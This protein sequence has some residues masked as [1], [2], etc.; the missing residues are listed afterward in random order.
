MSANAGSQATDVYGRNLG[1]KFGAQDAPFVLT[2]SLQCPE[3]AVTEVYVN[4][5]LGRLSDPIPRVDAYMICLMLRDLPRNLYWEE[6]RQVSAF[7]LK[8]GSI[9]LEESLARLVKEG[10]VEPE[11]ARARAAHPEEFENLVRAGS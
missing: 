6:G 11:E 10:L 4:Q 5:P 7:S 9:T 3:L 2:R 8:A 1:E